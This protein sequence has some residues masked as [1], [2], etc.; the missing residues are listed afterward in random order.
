MASTDRRRV[1]CDERD[2]DL[3]AF[4]ADGMRASMFTP[5]S[6]GRRVAIAREPGAAGIDATVTSIS[7]NEHRA[8]CKRR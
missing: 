8:S 5:A 7:R 1:A 6:A 4:H 3:V 2:A